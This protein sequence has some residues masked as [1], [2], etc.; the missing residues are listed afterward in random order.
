MTQLWNITKTY[1][2]NS[3]LASKE[4]DPGQ[5]GANYIWPLALYDTA[6]VIV[7]MSLWSMSQHLNFLVWF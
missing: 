2:A 3:K 6:L 7:V 4:T 1:F 5:L